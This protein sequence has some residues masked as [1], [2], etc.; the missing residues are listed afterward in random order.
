MKTASWEFS[1]LELIIALAASFI[2]FIS[3]TTLI[4]IGMGVDLKQS[5]YAIWKEQYQWM[6]PYY[7]G[8]GFISFALMFGYAYADLLGIF[9]MIIPMSLLRISQAQYVEHTRVV[10]SELRRKNQELENNSLEIS[11]LNDGLLGTLSEIIDLRDPYVLDHSKKVAK[12]AIKIAQKM[13]LHEKRI[14]LIRKAGLLH[15]IGKL[16]IPTEILSK[17]TRLTSQEYEIIKSH[18][19]VG[20]ALMQKS[21]SLRPLIP[22]VRHHHEYYDGNGYP[23]RLQGNEIPIEARVVAVADAI[24]AMTSDRPYHK[25]L[26]NELIAAELKRCLGNQF[27]PIVAAAAIEMLNEISQPTVAETVHRRPEATA[28]PR[29][30]IQSV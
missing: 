23:D 28:M 24:E 2:L 18:V 27:D 10:V 29:T 19:T 13:G 14:E 17:Q 8:I 3:T 1:L 11:Q 9:T 25:G 30:G 7:L 22:I 6:A 20:A 26:R 4:S 12:Y 5:P 16:G 15:D 21:P